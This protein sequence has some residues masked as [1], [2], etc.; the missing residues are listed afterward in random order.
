M[1][2][3]SSAAA[4]EARATR[5]EQQLADAQRQAE[6]ARSENRRL[7]ASLASAEARLAEAQQSQVRTSWIQSVAT[8]CFREFKWCRTVRSF[9]E[10][11]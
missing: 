3:H 4:L 10:G 11:F 9:E 5:A 2:L 7:A 8:S 6:T 1:Q